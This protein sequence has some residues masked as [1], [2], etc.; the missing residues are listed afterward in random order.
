MVACVRSQDAPDLVCRGCR[1][2]EVAEDLCRLVSRRQGCVVVVSGGG[3]DVEGSCLSRQQT[4]AL[5]NSQCAIAWGSADR[6][7]SCRADILS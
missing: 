6:R 4:A 2:D 3:D 5:D 7:G 1:V